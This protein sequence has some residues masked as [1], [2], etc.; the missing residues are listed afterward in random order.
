MTTLTAEDRAAVQRFLE[1]DYLEYER[2]AHRRRYVKDPWAWLT[3][4]VTT[5]DELDPAQP[6]KP[7][8]VAACRPCAR[9]LGAAEA[10]APCGRCGGPATPLAYLE[11][12]ARTWHRAEVPILIVP[13]ARRMIL[14]WLFCA[15]HAWLAW[16]RPYAKIFLVSS[17]ESKSAELLDRVHGI[18]ERVPT[19]RCAPLKLA[20]T[21]SPPLLQLANEA[22]VFGVAEGADQLRQYT[23]TAILAD[24][25]GTWTWP[26]AAYTAFKPCTDAGGRLTLVSSAY[27]GFFAELVRGE[28][29]G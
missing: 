1:T 27:P 17:K 24:E 5:I 26:R 2:E 20:R 21:L 3:E 22:M 12:L 25:V 23:A 13:K 8:P 11:H 4:C 9:Y 10:S 14:S 16:T 29:L 7:F 15:L 6:V 18:L 19:E 28:V